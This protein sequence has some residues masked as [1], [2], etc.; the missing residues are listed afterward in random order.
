[1]PKELLDYMNSRPNSGWM[2]GSV[3]VKMIGNSSSWPFS[4]CDHALV[5]WIYAE[6]RQLHWDRDPLSRFPL[7]FVEAFRRPLTVHRPLQR[8]SQNYTSFPKPNVAL[9]HQN[10]HA[11]VVVVVVVIMMII[12]LMLVMMMMMRRRRRRR[13][14]TTSSIM[15]FHL[16]N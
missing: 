9:S 6:R 5:G 10:G 7:L 13:T 15:N 2:S 1:M 14:T 11:V 12:M 3:K 16:P 4:K 8:S